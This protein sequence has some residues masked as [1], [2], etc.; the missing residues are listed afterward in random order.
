M[1][2][3][4]EEVV[5]KMIYRIK[6]RCYVV[7]R[8]EY[9]PAKH[10]EVIILGIDTNWYQNVVN[11][12]KMH[13]KA[14]MDLMVTFE[15]WNYEP[16]EDAKK[17][18]F[19]VRDRIVQA[20]DGALTKEAKDHLHHSC[21]FELGFPDENVEPKTSIKQ[22]TRNELWMATNLMVRWAEQTADCYIDDLMP[23]YKDA[24]GGLKDE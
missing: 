1:K 23:E 15:E 22:L 4:Y 8:S 5:E 6:A 2:L 19:K 20:Q 18:Y 24:Q 17:F 13:P 14:L 10:K 16:T 3:G 21:L 11:F 12:T 7:K 9:D